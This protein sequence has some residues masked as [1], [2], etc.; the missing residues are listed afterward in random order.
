MWAKIE[1]LKTFILDSYKTLHQNLICCFKEK[2]CEQ[3]AIYALLYSEPYKSLRG[4]D[5]FN[6]R[7]TEQVLNFHSNII[8][9]PTIHNN[10][11]KKTLHCTVK[12][13]FMYFQ[14]KIAYK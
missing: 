1:F 3:I 10:R 4:T 2:L 8:N 9:S 6:N 12:L 5:L 13:Y 7:Q 14:L 11:Q